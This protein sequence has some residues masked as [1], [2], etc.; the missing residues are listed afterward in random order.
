MATMTADPA[1][2][3]PG[4]PRALF[5]RLFSVPHQVPGEVHQPVS[6][7]GRGCWWNDPQAIPLG[8]GRGFN[9]EAVGEL[10]FQ[11]EIGAIVG[12]R[13][14]GG[15]NCQ[16]PAELVPVPTERDPGAVGIR[17]AGRPVG[18][19]P[20]E[21]AR[22]LRPLLAALADRGKAITCKAK[23]VGGWDR[24]EGDRGYFGVK[25]SLAMSPAV[26]REARG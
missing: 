24:G 6:F 19:L 22:Q 12:G 26:H 9:I 25:L 2:A 5:E 11:D 1:T 4:A 17:I 16:V 3:P 21:A 10:Q 14:E 7:D 15:H 8:A 20:A 23:I 13:C 18:Y